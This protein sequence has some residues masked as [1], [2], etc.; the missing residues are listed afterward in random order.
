MCDVLFAVCSL[1]WVRF[2]HCAGCRACNV[3]CSLS[4]VRTVP[5]LGCPHCIVLGAVCGK[6]LSDGNASCVQV[7]WEDAD[8]CMRHC[9]SRLCNGYPLLEL[10][11]FVTANGLTYRFQCGFF[12]YLKCEWK[13]RVFIPFNQPYEL[14]QYYA[15]HPEVPKPT[16]INVIVHTP[17]NMSLLS[18]KSG[19]RPATYKSHLCYIE[20]KCV[21]CT[22]SWARAG[23]P[24]SCHMR[25][26]CTGHC[27]VDPVSP[28]HQFLG[29]A[30]WSVLGAVCAC[31]CWVRSVCPFGC[32]LCIHT[33]GV[34]CGLYW[35]PSVL[36][37]VGCAECAHLGASCAS[38]PW[39]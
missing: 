12:N 24:V 13:L 1:C 2:V 7:G 26:C 17:E 37:T 38:A 6:C 20:T 39:V 19:L 25:A 36:A 10:F 14:T 21:P 4:W 33:L 29:C 22:T 34:V 30:L 9:D 28:V 32:L 3:L 16:V 27:C 15:A 5:C 18:A 35:V 23:C 31:D 8:F 11:G